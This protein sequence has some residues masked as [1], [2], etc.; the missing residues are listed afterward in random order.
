M[1]SIY[2]LVSSKLV[3]HATISDC[4]IHQE[5]QHLEGFTLVNTCK[6]ATLS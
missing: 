1:G 6:Y 3:F 2:E 5:P 4:S